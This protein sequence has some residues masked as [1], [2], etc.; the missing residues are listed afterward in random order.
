MGPILRS[1]P[2]GLVQRFAEFPGEGEEYF[3]SMILRARSSG[4]PI[5]EVETEG[6]YVQRKLLSPLQWLSI[7]WTAIRFVLSSLTSF[8]VDYAL[9][10]LLYLLVSRN[11]TFCTVAARVVSSFVNYWINRKLV[12]KSQSKGVG[13]L[14]RYYLLAAGLLLI[15]VLLVN[16][17]SHVLMIPALVAKPIV[18]ICMYVVSFSVQ[19]DVVF[20]RKKSKDSSSTTC[21]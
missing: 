6:F 4:I 21:Q 14:V 8:G 1:I 7:L 12:F 15:N 20:K 10:T 13:T 19:R 5:Q 3:L 2:A 11:V 16:L 18:E 17:L 9:F